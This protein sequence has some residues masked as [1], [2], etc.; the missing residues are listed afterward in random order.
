MLDEH[1]VNPRLAALYDFDSG[2]SEDRDFYLNLAGDNPIDICDF[3]CGTGLI[4]D[5][6]AARGHRVIGVDPAE[7][8]LAIARTKPNGT[9]IEWVHAFSQDYHPDKRFDL[10][11]MT[12]HAFQV[13]PEEKDVLKVF[14]NVK[15]LLKSGGRFVFETR[16]AAIDWAKKWNEDYE[17]QTP[18]GVVPGACRVLKQDE[19]NISFEQVYHLPGETL[20]SHSE[21]RFWPDVKIRELAAQCGLSVAAVFGDWQQGPFDKQSSEEMVFVL[22]QD[23]GP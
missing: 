13:L 2:W 16:N 1:Y 4:A 3:G 11:I 15:N 10:I 20:I 22:M 17:I 8:M 21:L 6:Y 18:D 23:G 19:K 7:A 12:G 14:A 5:A 9:K